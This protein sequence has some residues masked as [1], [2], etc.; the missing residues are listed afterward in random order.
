MTAGA[1]RP[2]PAPTEEGGKLVV[3][4]LCLSS[5][6]GTAMYVLGFAF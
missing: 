1:G 2:R 6:T 3:V 4:G 5:A